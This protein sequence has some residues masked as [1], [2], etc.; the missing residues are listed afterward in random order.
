MGINR[1]GWIVKKNRELKVIS[2]FSLRINAQKISRSSI[3][4]HLSSNLLLQLRKRNQT[5]WIVCWKRWEFKSKSG[6]VNSLWLSVYNSYLF[7]S[8]PSYSS[9]HSLFIISLTHPFIYWVICYTTIY[10]GL[11]V[12][13]VLRCM[14]HK[15]KEN[16]LD[17]KR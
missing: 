15:E 5:K 9:E 13:Q 2:L 6:T 7:L 14:R 3:S 1:P 10:W 4:S 8:A 16:M 12:F 11:T 17:I